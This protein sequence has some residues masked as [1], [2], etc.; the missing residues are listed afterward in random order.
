MAHWLKEFISDGDRKMASSDGGGGNAE[1]SVCDVINERGSV[2]TAAS[3]VEQGQ[4]LHQHALGEDGQRLPE[5][6]PC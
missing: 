4:R 5:V 1:K 3:E 2:C 6:Q